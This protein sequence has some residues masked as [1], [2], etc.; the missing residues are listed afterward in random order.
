MSFS[1]IASDYTKTGATDFDVYIDSGAELSGYVYSTIKIDQTTH[2]GT[3]KCVNMLFF[4]G[5][6]GLIHIQSNPPH[7][8]Q[9]RMAIFSNPATSPETLGYFPIHN[10]IGNMYFRDKDVIPY[11]NFTL[12]VFCNSENGTQLVFEKDVSPVWRT[13]FK[14]MPSRGVWFAENDNGVMLIVVGLV[15][16]MVFVFL[17]KQFKR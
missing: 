1:V 8:P 6:S 10:G 12:V 16:I 13:S 17:V 9:N 5:A 2:P 15:L 14:Q 7:S 11:N 3:Y 4:D